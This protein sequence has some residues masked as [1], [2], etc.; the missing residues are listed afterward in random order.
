MGELGTGD[1]E[2]RTFYTKVTIS[3][4]PCSVTMIA[5]G[6]SHTLIVTN[7]GKCYGVGNNNSY[8]LGLSES[9][10]YNAFSLIPLPFEPKNITQIACGGEHTLILTIDG[11]CYSAGSYK[12]SGHDNDKFT[13]VE[14]PHLKGTRIE[15]IACGD[16][17]SFMLTNEGA[18][19]RSSLSQNNPGFNL[20]SNLQP[21]ETVKQIF[22]RYCRAYLFSST[23]KCY[24]ID[25]QDELLTIEGL[26]NGFEVT[27]VALGYSNIFALNSAGDCYVYGTNPYVEL[28]LAPNCR[29]ADKF[30]KVNFQS[31]VKQVVCSVRHTVILDE[32]GHCYVSGDNEWGQLGLGFQR[33]CQSFTHVAM[34]IKRILA[35]GISYTVLE[36][37]DGEYFDSG[38]YN[39]NNMQFC[40]D[41]FSRVQGSDS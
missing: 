13:E 4:E 29:R 1:S 25:D 41:T 31:K 18:C 24:S 11:K 15:Q 37:K 38:M 2:D 23:G 9:T 7:T 5:R 39:P 16:S 34:G 36:R 21:G 28:G 12:G 40:K 20:I 17:S 30:T 19:Y 6:S 27:H 35:C 33:G 22:A 26:P 32:N 14:I 8:Q 10:L 3:N